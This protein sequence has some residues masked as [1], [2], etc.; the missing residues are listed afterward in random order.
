MRTAIHVRGSLFALAAVLMASS[1]TGCGYNPAYKNGSF[2][3]EASGAFME[4]FIPTRTQIQNAARQ[5]GYVAGSVLA[6]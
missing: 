2:V 3:D 6:R 1:L 4:G 5:P